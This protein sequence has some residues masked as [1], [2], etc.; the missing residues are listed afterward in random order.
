MAYL[1]IRFRIV[2]L[3]LPRDEINIKNLM[4]LQQSITKIFN[5][6]IIIKNKDNIDPKCKVIVANHAS[7]LD[8]LIIAQIMYESN[9]C[10]I[11][12][13]YIV[14]STILTK[15]SISRNIIKGINFIFVKRGRSKDIYKQMKS[16]VDAGNTIIICPQ[17][18]VS[19]NNTITEFRESAFKLEKPVLPIAI[20]YPNNIKSCDIRDMLCMDG[21]PIEVTIL[22]PIYEPSK[23]TARDIVKQMSEIHEFH[24]SRVTGRDITD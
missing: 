9:I 19:N 21:G 8:T 14:A 7:T 3:F 17:G 12:Q 24:F 11:D 1:Y 18:F 23:E 20:K 22:K 16:V 15:S 4:N 5:L 13:I 2:Q 10:P 6:Q